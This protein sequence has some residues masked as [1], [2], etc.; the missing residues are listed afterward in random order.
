MNQQIIYKVTLYNSKHLL[1]ADYQGPQV[2]NALLIPLGQEKRYQ[3]Q[4]NNINYLVEEQ[5]Y[6][7]FPQ[8]VA[9]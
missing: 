8:K 7:I 3:T 9:L 2:E 1:D 5:N 4:K 6:A